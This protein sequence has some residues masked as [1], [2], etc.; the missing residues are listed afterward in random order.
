MMGKGTIGERVYRQLLRLY[1][2]DFSDD[3]ADEMT[4]LYRDR[5]RGEGATSVWLTLVADLVRTAS[6]V[7]QVV[8]PGLFRVLTA[9]ALAGAT[10]R[11]CTVPAVR[12]TRIDPVIALRGD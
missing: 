10:A 9:L 8:S 5:V 7:E 11:A 1:P 3:Y 2:R 6:A 4:R 12:A